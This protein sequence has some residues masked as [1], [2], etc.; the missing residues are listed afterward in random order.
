[1]W[2]CSIHTVYCVPY[3]QDLTSNCFVILT[4][5]VLGQSF[6]FFSQN[7]LFADHHDNAMLLGMYIELCVSWGGQERFEHAS[8]AET[9]LKDSHVCAVQYNSDQTDSLDQ[10]VLTTAAFAEGSPGATS[11][12]CNIINKR[13]WVQ[14][15]SG[16][17][18]SWAVEY[19]HC[20]T[21]SSMHSLFY[22]RA[23]GSA[24]CN[25]NFS[26]KP[27][28]SRMH[29]NIQ[30]LQHCTQQSYMPLLIWCSLPSP[31][32]ACTDVLSL[33]SQPISLHSHLMRDA[34]HKHGWLCSL[35]TQERNKGWKVPSLCCVGNLTA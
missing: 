2:N 16:D 29:G 31:A 7:T 3:P 23:A 12:V 22:V 24:F 1:M 13:A 18:A 19:T 8:P 9:K 6:L 20:R 28:R 4:V 33:S 34:N 30:V 35:P 32:C 25:C 21:G 14:E 15:W 27:R 5:F 10:T 26:G 11:L 17:W